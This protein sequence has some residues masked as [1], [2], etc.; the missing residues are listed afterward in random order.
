MEEGEAWEGVAC[1][2]LAAKYPHPAGTQSP[3]KPE[4]RREREGER[5][6]HQW[7]SVLVRLCWRGPLP[8]GRRLL[9]HQL[10]S[11]SSSAQTPT[12]SPSWSSRGES[13]RFVTGLRHESAA[14]TRCFS[15]IAQELRWCPRARTHARTPRGE[16][17]FWLLEVLN[18]YNSPA[19]LLWGHR[20]EAVEL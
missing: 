5:G 8:P 3:L 20:H 17:D 2:P 14:R 9:L 7:E 6:R 11:T 18:T 15:R 12:S 10:I 4:N 1:L 19:R 16:R 13:Q